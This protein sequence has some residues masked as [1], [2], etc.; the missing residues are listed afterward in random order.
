MGGNNRRINMTQKI[1]STFL[2]ER[3]SQH[4]L[5]IPMWEDVLTRF[6]LA[7]FIEL[8]TWWG[9]FSIYFLMFCMN[10]EADFITYDTVRRKNSRLKWLLKFDSC[11]RKKDVF[12][13]YTEIAQ[14]IAKE[15]RTVLFCD[16]G[17]KQ[18]ELALFAPCL[19]SGDIIAVH[20]WMTEVFPDANTKE[21][22]EIPLSIWD[23]VTKF[24]IKP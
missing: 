14:E 21:L 5:A 8:G 20:D 2:G 6:K 17:D 13:S 16:N 12:T 22:T 15:G 1:K 24:F 7:R 3:V 23:G 4:Y 9:N 18:K 19:K 11:H 10:R